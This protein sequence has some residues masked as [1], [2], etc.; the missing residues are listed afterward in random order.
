MKTKLSFKFAVSFGTILLL[1]LIMACSSFINMQH[2]KADLIKIDEANK[3]MSLADDVAVQYK[4][5]I[6]AIRGYA[7]YGETAY[8]GQIDSGFENM[9]AD[10]KE[11]LTM[12]REDK[13]QEVQNVIDDTTQYK[14]IITKDY[15][16]LVKAYHTAKTAGD[17]ALVW[18]YE[19]KLNEMTKRLAPLDQAITN[20]VDGFAENNAALAKSLIDDSKNR[21]DNV[22][23]FSLVVSL[24]VLILGLVIAIVLTK[25][26]RN[27]I[28]VLTDATKKYAAGDL[29]DAIE[30]HSSDEIGELGRSL[31]VMHSHFVSMITG[32]RSASEQLAAAS[33]QTAASIEEVTS[34]SES[35]SK[36][37]ERLSGEAENG[38]QSMLEA[39]QALVELSSLIQIAKK[40]ANDTCNNSQETLAAAENGRTKV[41]ESVSKMDNI[42][43]Q[44]KKSSQ[45]ISEL[46]EYSQ[47][48]SQIIDT[49]TSI[50][51]QT[52]LLALNAAIEAARAGEH[53]RGFA[54]VAE[55]VRQLAE[56]S[57]QGAQEITS[58]VQKVTEKTELAVAAMAQNV[59]EVE[60]GVTT[61][62]E[63]GL[64]LDKILQ[65][66]TLMAQE[67]KEIGDVTS[68]QVANSDQIVKL[69]NDLSSVIETVAAHSGEVLASDQEQ[70][71]AL[72]TVAASAEET[73]A[74]ANELEKSVEQFVV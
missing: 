29:R 43:A 48:I 58:L 18:E 35:V 36:S 19:I 55:E 70:S 57:N 24:V 53:G 17:A 59:T 50:A 11:L 39:S 4:A 51:K 14:E 71:S 3:R 60:G 21:V 33:E 32:I 49:I 5:T 54:V 9:V 28:I 20:D 2:S 6:A 62:N 8:L 44:T 64:A 74:M 12:A 61:V 16:P 26:I 42:T 38:N 7:A 34:T 15:I 31:S 46:S 27:P 13:R 30:T 23:L 45:I 25:T 68:E 69:I 73:S 65:A 66:V 1:I 56:Q 67:A 40:K 63:A 52:N 37:M 47:Q 41:N 10:E 72:Q 22:N